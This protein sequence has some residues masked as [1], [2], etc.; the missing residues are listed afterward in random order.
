MKIVCITENT[1]ADERLCAEHGLSLYIETE[2]HKILFDMGQTDAFCEN[3]EKLGVRLEDVDIAVLSHGHY[4]HG[5]GLSRFLQVNKK[6]PV[7]ISR[8][9][10]G[11]YYNGQEKYIGLDISLKDSER[12]IFT[13]GEKD[14]GGGMCLYSHNDKKR[15][16][17][18][19]SFG[20][21]KRCDGEFVSDDFIHEHYL[22][23]E[24]DGKRVLISGCSHKGVV[25]IVSWFSPDVFVG[26]FHF[27][28]LACDG[29][30]TAAA[31]ELAAYPTTF[32][33][34][35]CTG[36]E[37]FEWMRGAMPSLRYLSCGECITV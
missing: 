17:Y 7:Y 29:R 10:F 36:R 23:I 3:A 28:K 27:S 19:G 34:C 8:Y 15:P 21:N 30:L 20:L 24:E 5:G 18:M 33:T 2:K 16:N 9:A 11:E 22:L 32:Y 12:F 35:H 1:S 13:D 31:R 37:Q 6:A 26:G 25:D 14:L 4:D